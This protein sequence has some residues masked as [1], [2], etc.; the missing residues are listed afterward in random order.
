[1]MNEG[2]FGA[3]T[4]AQRARDLLQSCSQVLF[5]RAIPVLPSC[6]TGRSTGARFA[7]R[8]ARRGRS[9]SRSFRADSGRACTRRRRCCGG[10]AANSVSPSPSRSPSTA[11]CASCRKRRCRARRWPPSCSVL[12][13]SRSRRRSGGPRRRCRKARSPAQWLRLDDGLAVGDPEFD[14]A[15]FVTELRYETKAAIPAAELCQAFTGAYAERVPLDAQRIALYAAHKETAKLLRL[16]RAP[17]PDA[18]RRFALAL[19]RLEQAAQ[20]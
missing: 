20:R 16:A 3:F 4:D 9:T 18:P 19:Q 1:M 12:A 17:R 5:W 2:V 10:T 13:A 6:A 15:T 7:L 11:I 14:V 8:M